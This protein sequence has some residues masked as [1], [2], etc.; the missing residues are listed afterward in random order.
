MKTTNQPNAAYAA[1]K[2]MIFPAYRLVHNLS[3]HC[4]QLIHSPIEGDASR[5]HFSISEA[6]DFRLKRL[7]FDLSNENDFA[8]SMMRAGR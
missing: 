5:D 8:I 3:T 7:R 1:V 2:R 4:P 6:V